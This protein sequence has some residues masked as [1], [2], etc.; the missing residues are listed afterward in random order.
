MLSSQAR[1]ATATRVSALANTVWLLTVG[2]SDPKPP[3][4]PVTSPAPW[5]AVAIV[6]GITPL[7]APSDEAIPPSTR[8][9]V[10]PAWD[11]AWADTSL[12]EGRER[13]RI[14]HGWDE[15]EL[16]LHGTTTMVGVLLDHSLDEQGL[17]ARL[18][19]IRSPLRRVVGTVGHPER[20]AHD[21]PDHSEES[22][23]LGAPLCRADLDR[24]QPTIAE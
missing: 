18:G 9:A 21:D 24:G 15:V 11:D 20:W 14:A 2:C 12:V 6:R 23:R 3:Q 1:S 17:C 7:D 8:L 10:G 16:L 4:S 19:Q 5:S 13:G 22:L